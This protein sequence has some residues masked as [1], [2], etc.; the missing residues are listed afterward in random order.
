MFS[1]SFHSA[2]PWLI[3]VLI[4]GM[5]I[6]A[7]LLWLSASLSQADAAAAAPATR[8][9]TPAVVP[10][11]S[12]GWMNQTASRAPSGLQRTVTIFGGGGG[13]GAPDP[14]QNVLLPKGS[15]V[16]AIYPPTNW[17]L[18]GRSDASINTR[19]IVAAACGSPSEAKTTVTLR[20]PDGR[21]M[22][23]EQRELTPAYRSPYVWW[24]LPEAALPG[25]YVLSIRNSQGTLSAEINV[26]QQSPRLVLKSEPDASLY[27]VA[28]G[29]KLLANYLGFQPGQTVEAGLYRS[30]P[31]SASECLP[32]MDLIDTWQFM[33]DAQGNY[34]EEVEVPDGA[35]TGGYYWAACVPG[36]CGFS[37]MPDS[38]ARLNWVWQSFSVVAP[39][40]SAQPTGEP[41]VSP[42]APNVGAQV[43]VDPVTAWNGLNM[44]SGRG[45][46]FPKV[47]GLPPESVVT[48]LEE[49]VVM[50][51]IPWY[52]G[53]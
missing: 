42:V 46:K 2:R 7:P 53:A 33:T 5:L 32:L 28:P 16:W 20:A 22:R 1:R 19:S 10:T 14:C 45:Y 17:V 13:E 21:E 12:V 26:M 50:D 27:E 31:C 44:R 48:I 36:E 38:E 30:R 35:P 3:P 8:S 9:P 23:P 41:V 34:H 4:V 52:R 29:Q 25:D 49:P 39:P 51:D 18:L 24:V 40:E 6:G 37:F 43:I 11:R 47:M 15:K